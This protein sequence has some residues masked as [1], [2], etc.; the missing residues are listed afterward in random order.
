MHW[1][2]ARKVVQPVRLLLLATLT[3]SKISSPLSRNLI[4]GLDN[5]DPIQQM[6]VFHRVF[7][8]LQR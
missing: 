8:S 7:A 5:P 4:P 3:A 2:P 1:Q 6:Q